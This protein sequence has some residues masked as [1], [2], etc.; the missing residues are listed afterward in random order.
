MQKL[1]TTLHQQQ[2]PTVEEILSTLL[3]SGTLY[4]MSKGD[5]VMHRLIADAIN[6]E[7]SIAANQN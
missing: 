3:P 6:S 4:P 2:L 5:Q 1:A 7:D